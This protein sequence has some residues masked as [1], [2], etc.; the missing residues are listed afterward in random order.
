MAA[1]FESRL[2]INGEF[3][4]SRS[5]SK[6]ELVNPATTK[7]VTAVYE[8]GVE[9]VDIAVKAAGDAFDAWSERPA[10]ERCRWLNRL[11][12]GLEQILPEVSRLEAITMGRPIHNDF[13]GVVPI[14]NVCGELNVGLNVERSHGP[15]NLTVLCQQS[16]RHP[17]RDVAERPEPVRHDGPPAVRSD[18]R[19]HP[20]EHAVS[21][22]VHEDWP[23]ADGWKHHGAQE[24]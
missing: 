20:V 14:F 1:E 21:H 19:H 6:F 2:F 3:V 10:I 5:G 17:G 13:V 18:G 11:C 24:L 15:A 4:P 23:S 16:H 9:D 7:V 22:A 12:D 8:A